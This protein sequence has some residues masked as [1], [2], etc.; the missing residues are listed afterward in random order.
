MLKLNY[1]ALVR[2]FIV[3]GIVIAI[4]FA[5]IDYG[6]PL[7]LMSLV[8]VF[9][10]FI[11][12]DYEEKNWLKYIFLIIDMLFITTMIY[13]TGFPYLS[14]F[15][16]P[17]I[18]D[19]I[20]NKKEIIFF[21][22]TSLIPVGMSLYISNFTDFLFIPLILG[23]LAGTLKLKAVLNKK[24]REIKKLKEDAE[25]IYIQNIK[26]QDKLEETK[27]VLEILRLLKKLQNNDISLK[28]FI[29][30]LKDIL[31]A[32]DIVFFDYINA[33][34]ISTDRNKCDKSVLKYIKENPQI[35]TKDIVNEK[36]DSEYV[37]SLILEKDEHII[38]VLFIVFKFKPKDSKLFYQL[39]I[40]YFKIFEGLK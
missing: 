2:V 14:V 21:L 6:I 25:E 30:I 27:K 20:D 39:I 8:Y 31:E 7:I 18:S 12:F 15:I 16:I 28:Q 3:L 23:G 5:N 33:K 29:Y 22:L 11:I 24:D 35:F 19:F 17:I 36:F 9:L 34:C 10:Y 4:Y 1:S 13:L 26:L 40:D 37:V 32:D 38:G